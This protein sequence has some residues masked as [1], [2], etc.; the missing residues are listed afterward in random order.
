MSQS[1]KS[2]PGPA[3]H[4]SPSPW[5]PQHA[6]PS[7]W[8]CQGQQKALLFRQKAVE[9]CEGQGPCGGDGHKCIR[10]FLLTKFGGNYLVFSQELI[11]LVRT[12]ELLSPVGRFSMMLPIKPR[13]GQT[14]WLAS[15]SS[16]IRSRSCHLESGIHRSELSP[17]KISL[18]RWVPRWREV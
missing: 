7:G 6:V 11:A 3:P 13:T 12:S 10:F 16:W 1:L 14:S 15:T 9:C 18:H 2:R 17:P 8:H 4:P 5:D